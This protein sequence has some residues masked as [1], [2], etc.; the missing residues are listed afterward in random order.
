ME[1]VMQGANQEPISEQMKRC[2]HGWFSSTFRCSNPF[3]LED[4][5]DEKGEDPLL[6]EHQEPAPS[7]SSSLLARISKEYNIICAGSGCT[8][9]ITDSTAPGAPVC[10]SGGPSVR[11]LGAYDTRRHRHA[12]AAQAGGRKHRRL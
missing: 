11:R 6:S 4:K 1:K 10:L 9:D 12:I 2:A 8:S 3:G 7:A 5:P